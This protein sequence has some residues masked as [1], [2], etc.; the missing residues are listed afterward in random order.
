MA[1]I[2]AS[3]RGIWAR[4]GPAFIGALSEDALQLPAWPFIVA[5]SGYFLWWAI[6]AGDLMWPVF[7]IIMIVFMLGRRGLRFPPGTV[8]WLFFLVWVL[9]SMSML[10]SVG[11]LIGAFY[12][13]GLQMSPLVFGIYAFNARARL[14]PKALM[15]TLWGFL[16]SAVVGGYLAMAFPKLRFNTLM[17]YVI[18]KALHS[19]DFVSEFVRRG[20]TQWNPG[21]WVLSDPRPSAP[22]IYANT[23][24]NVFSLIFP[25]AVIFAVISWREYARH[26]YLH[27][28]VCAASVVPAA[29]TLNRGMYIG[30]VVIAA[31]VGFQRVRDGRWRTV[32]V[33]LFLGGVGAI[34]WLFTPASQS[35]VERLQSSSTTVDR[36][37][38]YVETVA[39]LKESPLLGFGA[40]R[41]ASVPWLPSLGTQGQFWTVL[42]SYGIVGALLF[43]AF[44]AR[45]LPSVW[46]AKDIYGSVLGGIVIATLVEQFYYG[47]NTGLMVSVLAVALLA[48]HLEEGTEPLTDYDVAGP[49]A[50][51]PRGMW[52]NPVR[53]AEGEVFSERMLDRV[54]TSDRRG[55]RPRIVSRNRR[56]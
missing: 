46:R 30:L 26:R 47:M 54:S 36:F 35:L 51:T 33:A 13:F 18:P 44:F 8:I 55:R 14:T 19:N 41:P 24:G 2:A 42:F 37:T 27:A 6:G 34:A 10:D 45:I 56:R 29:A 23:W 53:R 25:L 4:P 28:L 39:S 22:F 21:S 20:T 38:N 48:R 52:K 49:A 1:E 3:R 11:R 32:L 17:Y 12:R 9:A 50:K 7:A 15:G 31:W 40:P 43:L 16:A 5:Y